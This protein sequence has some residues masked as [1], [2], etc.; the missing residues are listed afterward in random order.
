MTPW[1]LSLMLAAI[2]P[3]RQAPELED[4]ARA[5]YEAIAADVAEAVEEA[6]PLF[7][8][9]H[10]RH[11]TAALLLAVAL[12]ESAFRLEVDTGASRGDA[13]RSC[14]LWQFNFGKGELCDALLAD[15]KLAA[16]KAIELIR[17]SQKACRGPVEDM[18]RVYASG[19]CKKG[20]R[21]SRVRV[22]TAQR[23][24]AARPPP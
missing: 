18:L 13:G 6:P 7:R 8:G 10:G 16:R 12:H 24:F 1:I 23:W 4:L 17:R 9:K 19:S 2:P 11:R 15:R 21:E 20:E 3:A 14:T 5:R 22:E